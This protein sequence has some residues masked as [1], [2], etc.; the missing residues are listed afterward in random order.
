M[1][2]SSMRVANGVNKMIGNEAKPPIALE[3]LSCS[4]AMVEVPATLE[5]W[6]SKAEALWKLLDDVDTYGDMFKPEHTAYFKAVNYKLGERFK[7]MHSDGYVIIN[8]IETST[9]VGSE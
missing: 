4:A 1:V 2:P 7:H 8:V 3:S 9:K 5:Q 6:K